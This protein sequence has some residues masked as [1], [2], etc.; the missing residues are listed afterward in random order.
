MHQSLGRES[1]VR[2]RAGDGS[3]CSAGSRVVVH[4][5][6]P[7]ACNPRNRTEKLRKR[8]PTSV[9]VFPGNFDGAPERVR[10]VRTARGGA[11]TPP[12]RFVI[13][14]AVPMPIGGCAADPEGTGFPVRRAPWICTPWTALHRGNTRGFATESRGKCGMLKAKAMHLFF[15][16]A[17]TEGTAGNGSSESSLVGGNTSDRAP[18]PPKENPE[19]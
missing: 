8:V 18:R 7:A 19:S 5:F 4:G 16:E 2:V 14:R 3:E 17:M 6:H 9:G 11:S 13:N 12:R 15:S 1:P 10:R